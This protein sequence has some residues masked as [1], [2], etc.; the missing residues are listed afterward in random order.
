MADHI[1]VTGNAMYRGI[2]AFVIGWTG[3]NGAHA[4]T[5]FNSADKTPEAD[6][7]TS[8][9]NVGQT[10][11]MNRTDKR[12][13]VKLAAKPVGSN[14]AAALAIAADLPQKM[15]ILTVTATAAGDASIDSSAGTCVCDSASAKWS[16][17][18]ELTVDIE[19]TNWLGQTFTAFS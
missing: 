11:E 2:P 17:E 6:V 16:P 18:N 1:G 13:K 4:L 9:N 3:A 19:F 14:V 5:V 15:D 7:K 10:I 8:K 12:I